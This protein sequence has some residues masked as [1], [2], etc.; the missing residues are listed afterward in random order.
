MGLLEENCLSFEEIEAVRLR[1]L[2]HL[3]QAECAGKMNIS[4]STF[5]RVLA[6]ARLKI[7]DSLL[8]GKALRVEGGNYEFITPGPGAGPGVKEGEIKR[9]KMKIAV[10]TDDGK[11]ISQ[12]FGMA[13]QYVVADTRDGK[14][15]SKETRPKVG[16]ATHPV[17]HDHN[18]GCGGVHGHGEGAAEKHSAMAGSILDCQVLLAGGMGWGAYESMKSQNIEPVITDVADVDEALK[19]YLEGNL[20]NLMEKLH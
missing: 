5:Q 10:I 17:H 13:R 15:L 12:H 9:G 2:E 8:V 3:E 6:S 7:A 18:E 11:T 16:H 1:D 4:R 19:L 20:P 14:V